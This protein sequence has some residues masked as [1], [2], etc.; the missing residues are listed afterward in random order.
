MET[1]Q[2]QSGVGQTSLGDSRV[3]D[4]HQGPTLSSPD[5]SWVF[6]SPGGRQLLAVPVG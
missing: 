3:P 4:S 6:W 5:S 2:W 1:K